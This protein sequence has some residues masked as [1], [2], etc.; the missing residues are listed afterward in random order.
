MLYVYGDGLAQDCG[1]F[2]VLARELGTI[3]LR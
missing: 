2:I 3:V 1:N